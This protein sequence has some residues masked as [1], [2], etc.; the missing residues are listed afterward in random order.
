MGSCC[1]LSQKISAEDL[2]AEVKAARELALRLR[3]EEEER[4]LREQERLDAERRRLDAQKANYQHGLTMLSLEESKAETS[5]GEKMRRALGVVSG[6]LTNHFQLD[7]DGKRYLAFLGHH[8]N[9]FESF[10]YDGW[11]AGMSH[12]ERSSN[13]SEKNKMSLVSMPQPGAWVR[14][15]P[16]PSSKPLD[17][18]AE[19]LSGSLSADDLDVVLT[20][21]VGYVS[22]AVPPAILS[23]SRAGSPLSRAA[24][25]SSSTRIG[26]AQ[27]DPTE[28]TAAGTK[29]KI[30]FRER[31]RETS[32]GGLST[33]LSGARSSPTPTPTP[34]PA[35]ALT[36]KIPDSE[37]DEQSPQQQLEP[38]VHGWSTVTGDPPSDQDRRDG[39]LFFSRCYSMWHAIKRRGDAWSIQPGGVLGLVGT[40]ALVRAQT[41]AGG[42]GSPTSSYKAFDEV[43]LT[44]DEQMTEV[45]ADSL[46]PWLWKDYDYDNDD[47][48]IN[49]GNDDDKFSAVAT[50]AE[51]EVLYLRDPETTTLDMMPRLLD[52]TPEALAQQKQ[53]KKKQ[54][55]CRYL[56]QRRYSYVPF[57]ASPSLSHAHNLHML[58]IEA[59][60]AFLPRP[61][62][63]QR[64][65]QLRRLVVRLYRHSHRIPA[66]GDGK[67][68][69]FLN[70]NR[71]MLRRRRPEV[72]YANDA[73][74]DAEARRAE[75]DPYFDPKTPTS[76]ARVT[77]TGRK[78]QE[79]T[80][81]CHTLA[82]LQLFLQAQAHAEREL[83]LMVA[84]AERELM[85][86]NEAEEEADE[87]ERRQRQ[88]EEEAEALSRTS[89]TS[90]S[91]KGGKGGGSLASSGRSRSLSQI[92]GGSRKGGVGAGGST[93]PSRK[94]TSNTNASS[95]S[96]GN[97]PT[98]L[99]KTSSVGSLGSSLTGS[100]SQKHQP[101]DGIVVTTPSEERK[102]GGME[103]TSRS[104]IASYGQIKKAP[105]RRVLPPL[106][107]PEPFSAW[108]AAL[109]P[110]D[111]GC[112]QVSGHSLWDEM[113]RMLAA[114]GEASKVGGGVYQKS[115]TTGASASATHPSLYPPDSTIG[116]SEAATSHLLYATDG[117]RHKFSRKQKKKGHAAA[118]SN[119]GRLPVDLYITPREVEDDTVGSAKL[120]RE[121][122]DD[123]STHGAP[124]GGKGGGLTRVQEGDEDQDHDSNNDGEGGHGEEKRQDAAVLLPPLGLTS[125][126]DMVP[127]VLT[128]PVSPT[129]ATTLQ[130]R[131][132]RKA[133]YLLTRTARNKPDRFFA[134]TKGATL[135]KMTAAEAALR[136]PEGQRG[137]YVAARQSYSRFIQAHNRNS[138]LLTT[139][140]RWA[141]ADQA[142]TAARAELVDQEKELTSAEEA[143]KAVLA[144]ASRAAAS[145]SGT[146]SARSTEGSARST[147]YNASTAEGEE[148]LPETEGDVA[149]AFA[150]SLLVRERKNAV[151]ALTRRVAY[152][153]SVSATD[154]SSVEKLTTAAGAEPIDS[155][156]YLNAAAAAQA[157]RTTRTMLS[158]EHA[159][160]RHAVHT[161]LALSVMGQ[162]RSAVEEACVALAYRVRDRARHSLRVAVI[163]E[164]EAMF[165]AAGAVS[166]WLPVAR[167]T[168][169]KSKIRPKIK[170]SLSLLHALSKA[171][172]LQSGGAGG[173]L[174]TSGGL[175]SPLASRPVTESPIQS[176]ASSPSRP[177]TAAAMEQGS[178][179]RRQSLSLRLFGN[180]TDPSLPLPP[181]AR[182][183]T[184]ATA[185]ATTTIQS[186]RQSAR[187]DWQANLPCYLS[188]HDRPAHAFAGSATSN[189]VTAASA[190]MYRRRKRAAAEQRKVTQREMRQLLYAIADVVVMQADTMETKNRVAAEAER[191]EASRRSMEA[192]LAYHEFDTTTTNAADTTTDVNSPGDK[193]KKGKFATKHEAP[194]RFPPGAVS[195]A[196]ARYRR[197]PVA[198]SH[199]FFSSHQALRAAKKE[200]G[201]LAHAEC[202]P[203]VKD[204]LNE[205]DN[206]FSKATKEG[207]TKDQTKYGL[208]LSLE[209]WLVKG[210]C[211][212][213]MCDYTAATSS[214]ATAQEGC[215]GLFGKEYHPGH[216]EVLV[217]RSNCLI[218]QGMHAEAAQ[219]L[220]T[221]SE[222]QAKYTTSNHPPL[223]AK[224]PAAAGE[225]AGDIEGKQGGDADE[226]DDDESVVKR[227][228][229]PY[230]DLMER[231][232]GRYQSQYCSLSY[233]LRLAAVYYKMGEYVAC[234]RLVEEAGAILGNGGFSGTDPA[235]FDIGLT[236]LRAK[237][238]DVT[239][240]GG[241]RAV[242]LWS[243]VIS[244]QRDLYEKDDG[245]EVDTHPE[246]V[247]TMVHLATV[248]MER[249][250]LKQALSL[251]TQAFRI[252][253]EHY[254]DSH[255]MMAVCYFLKANYLRKHGSFGEAAVALAAC[256][257]T[258]R[259]HY[260]PEH[261]WRARCSLLAANIARDGGYP[262][263]ALP[264]FRKCVEVQE[265]VSS[266]GV[267]G[268][269]SPPS[270]A[271]VDACT[272]IARN[273]KDLGHYEES[274][275]WLE[276]ALALNRQLSAM[277]GSSTH[278][279]LEV[280]LVEIGDIK[281]TT[282][283]NAEGTK[284]LIAAGKELALMTGDSHL[285]VSDSLL[286]LG[287]AR[288]LI[289]RYTEAH[290]I[291]TRSLDIRVR[292]LGT[293]NPGVAEVWHA[294]ADNHRLHGSFDAA[295]EAEFAAMAIRSKVYAPDSLPIAD[296]LLVRANILRDLNKPEEALPLY[297]Q[298]VGIYGATCG[299]E[300]LLF[301]S[302]LGDMGECHRVLRDIPRATATIEKAV[303]GV[304]KLVGKGH[305]LNA[306][307]Q[308][309]YAMTAIDCMTESQL[310]VALVILDQSVLPLY[311]RLVGDMHPAAVFARGLVG[312]VEVLHMTPRS[313]RMDDTGG[314]VEVA[315]PQD[316]I[317]DALV[318]FRSYRHGPFSALHPW[319]RCLGGYMDIDK[320]SER[321][322][323]D[324]EQSELS[325][326]RT[327]APELGFTASGAA[328][329]ASSLTPLMQALV[330]SSFCGG[331]GP[332][333]ALERLVR[334][335]VSVR[336]DPEGECHF[337]LTLSF[338]PGK[339]VAG[340]IACSHSSHHAVSATISVFHRGENLKEKVSLPLALS[341]R[342]VEA[343]HEQLK[344]SGELE[345]A[346]VAAA[347]EEGG[348]AD[349]AV[350]VESAATA[351]GSAAIALRFVLSL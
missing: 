262:H 222:A 21:V 302:M 343:L 226:E 64:S 123:D 200:L 37:E 165:A 79:V 223:P 117:Q 281:V 29:K 70:R 121:D 319:V 75:Q 239:S 110:S 72:H 68:V 334:G 102:D 316:L 91:Q 203:L 313:T 247:G 84:R 90:E 36:I 113:L 327:W 177:F 114:R 71:F 299:D 351:N 333:T 340:G 185:T 170:P 249:G 180:D 266:V 329:T 69:P 52:L 50:A 325:D 9:K 273:F 347:L 279:N 268:E 295:V 301:C 112:T 320:L 216:F 246:L 26:T 138:L 3:S 259:A 169:A 341:R 141:A 298:A 93:S 105:R 210:Q 181:G 237:L 118:D 48:H 233:R 230:T 336:S 267:G 103:G 132:R 228:I 12:F 14:G 133:S 128:P 315:T 261:Y 15:L 282:G 80:D 41:A 126:T 89:S 100:R 33:S 116:P 161:G 290:S 311:E 8:W 76:S 154:K 272:C 198:R 24:S 201:L 288:S 297:E 182:R 346:T 18:K 212:M 331:Y 109:V 43:E 129:N 184:G 11:Q 338:K 217:A 312:L 192:A 39:L 174:L 115:D 77:Y 81:M 175:S 196:M 151:V 280:C 10:K 135:V 60:L 82:H 148:D 145:G 194:K 65:S 171:G 30:D 287:K 55:K 248:L 286:A 324:R 49:N 131:F 209:L 25:S 107:A 54:K 234:S 284:L 66:A 188:S 310:A 2:E 152:L 317:D 62:E 57:P 88:F 330:L 283:H 307:L 241:E 219:L 242:A 51:C 253:H 187:A 87:E 344:V 189:T 122:G 323:A 328:T 238:A 265:G 146:D 235:A 96:G 227:D 4:K 94:R 173:A 294:M 221:M 1:S 34:A 17:V 27:T 108:I 211:E 254:D 176:P 240:E 332:T 263:K 13:T 342:L 275:S 350:A 20:G 150:A 232:S 229:D 16:T 321:A 130:R 322:R 349:D 183:A 190:N 193:S 199:P 156:R 95:G 345:R 85:L 106:P 163:A 244:L 155:V 167:V 213:A 205:L 292:L 202:L 250:D 53:L 276:R 251:A 28:A 99:K 204:E 195:D 300:S 277:L 258:M 231:L 296:S 179:F 252:R 291:Y 32:G 308:L 274:L 23:M 119:G 335:S 147:R 306:D 137:A 326:N 45:F 38:L 42:G 127:P 59:T 101:Q 172:D 97:S 86:K 162:L 337:R 285:S 143:E 134:P 157:T 215:E 278:C 140:D 98:S 61:T 225:A 255:P 257:K 31:L 78:R 153:D 158:L 339:I 191:L 149:G 40:A 19:I 314:M 318:Y 269:P 207:C 224:D 5:E 270:R 63:R 303:Q 214:L 164:E 218:Y 47:R 178:D 125:S 289:G 305:I 206:D 124:D 74:A 245:E 6:T 309:R 168:T 236:S 35:P 56:Y 264:M 304:Q 293:S 208:Y 92:G 197:P 186:P 22:D 104:E 73:E 67:N 58:P 144:G 260:P 111:L 159:A 166:P 271:M 120:S 139:L 220:Q 46:R 44:G 142:A 136:D 243:R 256:E 160:T 348:E 83:H 7:H